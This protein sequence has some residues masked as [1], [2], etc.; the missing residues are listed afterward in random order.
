LY[1]Y[2]ERS[3]QLIERAKEADR[4]I[5]GLTL[6][7]TYRFINFEWKPLLN[8]FAPIR[9]NCELTYD[10]LRTTYT[11]PLRIGNPALRDL[12]RMKFGNC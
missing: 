5:E 6:F 1:D 10:V 9:F 7:F 2:T 11:N 8:E 12:Q 4:A 3:N